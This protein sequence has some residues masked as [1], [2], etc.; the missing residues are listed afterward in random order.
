MLPGV[1][2]VC[3]L[4]RRALLVFVERLDGC[5]L[6]LEAGLEARAR[7]SEPED[8]RLARERGLDPAPGRALPDRFLL[9][10]DRFARELFERDLFALEPLE[11]DDLFARDR[12]E[13][14]LFAFGCD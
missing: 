14:D 12:F 3:D 1:G 10:C 5:A 2:F 9:A 7:E 6:D 11:R 4:L 8:L 13:L